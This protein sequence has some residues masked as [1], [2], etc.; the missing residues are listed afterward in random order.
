MDDK[1]HKEN[2]KK[3]KDD[4]KQEVENNPKHKSDKVQAHA[5]GGLGIT[6]MLG[7]A[8]AE[9]LELLGGHVTEIVGGGTGVGIILFFLF[10]FFAIEMEELH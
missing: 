2:F 5:A 10:K 6:G 7:C 1:F 8:G 4:I 9:A 3:I